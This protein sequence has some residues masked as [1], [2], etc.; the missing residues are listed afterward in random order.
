MK[1]KIVRANA[2]KTGLLGAGIA[3]VLISLLVFGVS[4]TRPGWSEYWRIRPLIV[5]PIAAGMGGVLAYLFFRITTNGGLNKFIAGFLAV[6]GYVIS[7]W[8][9][10]VL[11]LAGTLWN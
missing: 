11:G 5:T 3:L 2:L 6:L 9:G 4:T 7:L 1:Q 8:L 10:S